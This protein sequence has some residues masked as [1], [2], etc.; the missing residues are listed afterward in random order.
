MNVSREGIRNI[1]SIYE[2]NEIS[3][4]TNQNQAM[5]SR[6]LGD[7][8]LEIEQQNM[9]YNYFASMNIVAYGG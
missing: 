9:T 1:H 6:V 8:G 3:G 2:T 4:T 5:V 7:W